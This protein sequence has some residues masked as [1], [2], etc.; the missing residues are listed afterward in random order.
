[1]KTLTERYLERRAKMYQS[2]QA[3]SFFEEQMAGAE[4]SLRIAS[5]LW[6]RSLASSGITM[7][8]GPQGSDA[9]AAQK[10]L[11]LERLD[12]IQNELAD[13]EVEVEGEPVSGSQ[14]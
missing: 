10:N 9:L 11:V 6:R 12:R 2:P 8:K 13:A 3:L 4:G 14:V 5:R 1:M 7:V